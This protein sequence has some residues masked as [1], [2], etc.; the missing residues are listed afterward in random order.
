MGKYEPETETTIAESHRSAVAR[1][2]V[3]MVKAVEIKS[4]KLAIRVTLYSARRFGF[5]GPS[6]RSSDGS[7]R[8]DFLLRNRRSRQTIAPATREKRTRCRSLPVINIST[9]PAAKTPNPIHWPAL[10]WSSLLEW[11]AGSR[12]VRSCRTR[13]ARR[14][15]R[16]TTLFLRSVTHAIG[17][18]HNSRRSLGFARRPLAAGEP[19]DPSRMARVCESERCRPAP[20]T[21]RPSSRGR[22]I[23]RRI[24]PRFRSLP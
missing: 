11:D 6:D 19:R 8:F 20:F 3:G 13:K 24:S 9:V 14:G 18:P 1:T 12:T 21:L 2:W 7:S 10:N 4:M 5:G 23:G 17:S 22:F 16:S 15:Y